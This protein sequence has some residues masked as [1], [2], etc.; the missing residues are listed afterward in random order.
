MLINKEDS[1]VMINL[2]DV[3]VG[4]SIVISNYSQATNRL[5]DGANETLRAVTSEINSYFKE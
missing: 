3:A 1:E 2:K 5:H 4:L